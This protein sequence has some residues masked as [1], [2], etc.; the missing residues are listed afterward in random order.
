MIFDGAAAIFALS[1]PSYASILRLGNYAD[2]TH[3]VP[4]FVDCC[5]A[6]ADNRG[7]SN[8]E[9]LQVVYTGSLI[10]SKGVFTLVDVAARLPFGRFRLIGDAPASARV[11]LIEHIRA[12]QVS[13]KVEVLG[14]I[15]HRD[16]VSEL[17]NND[18]LVFPSE[19]EGF[20]MSVV[21]AMAVGL[22]VVASP[23]GAIP[24][25]IDEP[26]GGY[27]VAPRDVDRYVEIL[28][29]LHLAPALRK[30]MGDYNR[31]KAR[32]EYDYD[33]V[34]D[35]ICAIYSRILGLEFSRGSEVA[36]C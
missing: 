11:E 1:Q 27:V 29:K 31:T 15:A 13:D 22:P 16:V 6:P 33:V 5:D 36:D 2:K 28:T 17:A 3:I 4:N 19:R 7:R 24:E 14:P 18:V 8:H 10:R 12:R 20:P 23:V 25:M 30:Q 32:R 34:V 9:T 35:R 21:E 26:N